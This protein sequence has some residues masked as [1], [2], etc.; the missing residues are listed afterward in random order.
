[1]KHDHN[2]IHGLK[3]IKHSFKSKGHN[4]LIHKKVVV[5]Q[6]TTVKRRK[7]IKHV[8]KRGKG[9]VRKSKKNCQY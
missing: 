8:F 1:M 6:G 9:L 5:K 3:R 7:V 2:K 4:T